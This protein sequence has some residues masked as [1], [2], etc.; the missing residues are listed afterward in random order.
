ME[1]G[2][3]AI[4]PVIASLERAADRVGDLT[5]LVYAR[6]FAEQPETQGLFWRDKSGQIRGEMLAKVFETILD[7]VGERQF[8]EH[9]IRAS[10]VVHT[11]YAVPENL[12]GT[13]FGVVMRTVRQVL[14]ETW[15][16]DTD[17]AWGCLLAD[18]DSVVAAAKVAA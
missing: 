3:S 16:S 17:A 1:S 14:G 2:D 5:S 9:L 12:F 8:A 15:D 13:F 11:E 4:H 6:L 7:F 18:L 10:L